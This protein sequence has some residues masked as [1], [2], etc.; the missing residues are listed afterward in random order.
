MRL[1]KKKNVS[2]AIKTFLF[3]QPWPELLSVNDFD[4]KEDFFFTSLSHLISKT[5]FSN[6]TGKIFIALYQNFQSDFLSLFTSVL[7]W[8]DD[9]NKCLLNDSKGADTIMWKMS[10][11]KNETKIEQMNRL[12]YWENDEC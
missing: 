10:A 5:T 7:F 11:A 9:E 4:T 3:R 8:D 12:F 2:D 6:F 1:K